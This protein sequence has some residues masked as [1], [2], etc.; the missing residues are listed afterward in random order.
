MFWSIGAGWNMENEEFLKDI[1]WI[2]QLKVRASMGTNGN[3]DGIGD[4]VTF[5]GYGKT[6]YNGNPGYVRTEAGNPDLKWETS[7]QFDFGVDFKGFD[8]RVSLSLDYYNKTT[9]D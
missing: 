3:Q 7:R 4:F 1:N 9:K 6:S 5:T 2:N 8:N